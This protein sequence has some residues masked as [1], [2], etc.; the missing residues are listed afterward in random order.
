[1]Q[2]ASYIQ[3]LTYVYRAF[4]GNVC[5]CNL[6]TDITASSQLLGV[7]MHNYSALHANDQVSTNDTFFQLLAPGEFR[8]ARF[9]GDL[10]LSLET[11]ERQAG[12]KR[13][14]AGFSS[15]LPERAGAAAGKHLSL[16]PN[17]IPEH[18]I[19]L[20]SAASKA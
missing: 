10:S 13:T 16:G 15:I 18:V 5:S 1:M 9:E 14:P 19:P 12:H 6:R 11:S 20:E 3:S 17:V 7:D 8:Q 2:D 4:R